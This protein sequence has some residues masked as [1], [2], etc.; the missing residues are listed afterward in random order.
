MKVEVNKTKILPKKTKRKMINSKMQEI[1]QVLHRQGGFMSANELSK[2]TGIAYITIRK[3]IEDLRDH[4]IITEVKRKFAEFVAI[5][6]KKNPKRSRTK[7]YSLNYGVIFKDDK[8]NA[9]VKDKPLYT[10][11]SL[12]F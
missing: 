1:I 12:P 2:E 10:T 5:T 4:L 6:K 9:Y 11:N 3:Y 8:K 7:R